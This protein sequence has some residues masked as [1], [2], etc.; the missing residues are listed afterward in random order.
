M[1]WRHDL[2][3]PAKGVGIAADSEG[4]VY[5]AELGRVVARD[6]SGGTLFEVP[7]EHISSLAVG[8]RGVLT[9]GGSRGG[10]AVILTV[11]G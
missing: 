4:R 3:F 7:L 1:R 8:G 9:I 11:S 10:Q 2:E 6:S 5:T